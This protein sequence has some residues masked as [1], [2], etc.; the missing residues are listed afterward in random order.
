MSL[1]A[2]ESA[3]MAVRAGIRHILFAVPPPGVATAMD[4]YLKSLAPEPSPFLE[5][6]KLS[7]AARRGKRLFEDRQVGC[8]QCHPGPLF[9]DLKSYDVGTNGRYTAAGTLFDT[10]TLVE[11][12]RTAPYLHDGSALTLVEVLQRARRDDKHGKVSHLTEQEIAD[13]AAYVLSL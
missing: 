9:T 4:T 5:K 7:A 2:R 3:E 1:S 10:P 12:W 8:A 11:L 6:G 13:L